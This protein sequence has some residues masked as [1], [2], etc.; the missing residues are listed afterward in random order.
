MR[1]SDFRIHDTARL[2]SI[3]VSLCGMVIQG[4]QQRPDHYGMVAAA[5]LDP[6]N[7]LIRALNHKQDGKSVHAERAAMDRYESK[8]GAIPDG[9][10]IVTTCSPCTQPMRDRAGSS[11]EDLITNSDVHKVYAGYRDP[12][13]QTDAQGKTYHLRIT[14]NKKIQDLCRE[15]ANTWLNDKLDELAFLGSPCTKDCSGH[16]AG[17]AWSQSKGG[18]VAN[19]P[20][21][22]SFNKGSQLH[23]DGK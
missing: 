11:C 12:S 13:Q 21:S 23:V 5:V 22:P 4:Q 1:I 6:D 15:F 20:F 14:R 9:S 3:L 16:R 7:R 10:I 17:Y 2:D 18:Q 19:S 8:Y